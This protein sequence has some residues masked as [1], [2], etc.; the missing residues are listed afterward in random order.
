MGAALSPRSKKRERACSAPGRRSTLRDMGS[1]A[2]PAVI[3]LAVLVV[4]L[5]PRAARA[6][7]PLCDDRGAI[8]FA[9]P[10]TLDAQSASIDVG[11]PASACFER[12]AVAGYDQGSAP[13]PAPQSAQPEV[14]PVHAGVHVL[15]A[16]VTLGPFD[17]LTVGARVGERWRV[18]RPPRAGTD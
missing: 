1:W 13:N 10:P 12:T 8:T 11:S 17:V 18:E 16:Q 2:R 5:A 7:A 6:A 9:P 14:A 3:V 4:W 15:P